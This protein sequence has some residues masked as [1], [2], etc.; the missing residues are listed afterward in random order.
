MRPGL[1]RVQRYADLLEMRLRGG[2]N[3]DDPQRLDC[4]IALLIDD[5]LGKGLG[6]APV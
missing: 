1:L 5:V 3:A 6:D 2:R 4:G